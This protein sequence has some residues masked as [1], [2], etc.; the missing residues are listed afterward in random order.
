SSPPAKRKRG[1]STSE[2]EIT[3]SAFWMPHGDIIL[4]AE[5]TQF[6]VNKDVLARHSPVFEG[7]FSLTLPHD[8]PTN[9][10][11]AVVRVMDSAKDWELLL[12]SL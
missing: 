3:R 8:E 11:C 7:M 9:E 10:G 6:R 5:S 1:D 12:Q 2:S 4:H